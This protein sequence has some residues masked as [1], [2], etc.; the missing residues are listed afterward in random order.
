M[1]EWLVE[2]W[3]NM[4]SARVYKEWTFGIVEGIFFHSGVL[5]DQPL[6]DFVTGVLDFAGKVNRKL[7]VGSVD[8]NS[9][10]YITYTE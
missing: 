1:A 10:S 7:V 8:S 9:G 4:T 5:N 3:Y 2:T 6:V